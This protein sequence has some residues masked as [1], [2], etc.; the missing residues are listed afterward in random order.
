MGTLLMK[1]WIL[2]NTETGSYN[3]LQDIEGGALKTGELAAE[4][5]VLATLHVLASKNLSLCEHSV[6]VAVAAV[7]IAAVMRDNG[8]GKN[9]LNEHDTFLAGLI[10]DMGK[11]SIDNAILKKKSSLNS[12]EREIMRRHSEWGH[13]L[14]SEIDEFHH[15]APYTLQH[16][17]RPGGRGYPR[18]LDTD[19]IMIMSRILNIADRF[20]GMIVDRPYRK[21]IP[22]EQIITSIA[23]DITDF[24]GN[25]ASDIIDTL[26]STDR[27]QLESAANHYITDTGIQR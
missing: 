21:A 5:C 18:G 24:F 23:D 1:A 22:R 8:L 2:Q 13:D 17:E 6:H 15:L 10:H 3:Y 26:L 16:H 20:C 27:C 14:V 9:L 4:N 7:D 19:S 11:L 12:C 25:Q